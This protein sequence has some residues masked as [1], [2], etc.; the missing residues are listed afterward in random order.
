MST[1]ENKNIMART[2][3][4]I[5]NKGN[6]DVV[7][8]THDKDFVGHT[9][10]DEMKGPE[11]VKQ[12]ASQYRNAFPDLKITNEDMIAEGD[13]VVSRQTVTGTH[14]GEFQ[15]IAPT[16]KKITVT[17][18]LIVRIVNGKIVETWMNMDSLGFMQQ[19]GIIPPPSK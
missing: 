9:S 15:G 8:E 10:S 12:F 14:K 4:E 17:S 6:L 3:E 13:M 1:E 11:S 5:F 2:T 16:G 18:I 19:L 7:D